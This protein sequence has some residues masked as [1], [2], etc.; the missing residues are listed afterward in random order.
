MLEITDIRKAL[1][2]LQKEFPASLEVD[3]NAVVA[4]QLAEQPDTTLEELL[5]HSREILIIEP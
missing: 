5:K 1:E 3:I 2:V 4:Y